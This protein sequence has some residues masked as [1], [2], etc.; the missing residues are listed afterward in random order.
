MIL[1][2]NNIWEFA[3]PDFKTYHW[4]TVIKIVLYIRGEK[5]DRIEARN[6]V[7]SI[8]RLNI[9]WM[10]HVGNKTDYSTN[11]VGIIVHSFEQKINLSY[12]F[13]PVPEINF[14]WI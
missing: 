13:T 3:L 14:S 4:S 5:N 6:Q 2:M 1:Q 12:Y 11:Q 8:W 9:K 7:K 10:W